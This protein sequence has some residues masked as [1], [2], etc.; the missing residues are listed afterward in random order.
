MYYF[1]LFFFFFACTNTSKNLDSDLDC[2][3]QKQIL[4]ELLTEKQ[5]TINVLSD[6]YQ[7]VSKDLDE[8]IQENPAL[9]VEAPSSDTLQNEWKSLAARL[10]SDLEDLQKLSASDHS[11]RALKERLGIR[12]KQMEKIQF[13]FHQMHEKVNEQKSEIE[14][15]E[16]ELS[17]VNAAYLDIFEN[18]LEQEKSN[19]KV[20]YYCAGSSVCGAWALRATKP[21]NAPRPVGWPTGL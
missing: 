7:S 5:L 16:Q 2:W 4:E 19:P 14:N 11:P 3:K 17:G 18:Y 9:L 10:K 8:L 6:F 13:I 21:G 12:A 20:Y 15:L 1:F